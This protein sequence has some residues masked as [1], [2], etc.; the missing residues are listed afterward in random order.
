VQQ[1]FEDRTEADYEDDVS[2]SEDIL[3]TRIR[4]V[5]ELIDLVKRFVTAES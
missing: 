1:A 3:R 2:F 5:N 4:D